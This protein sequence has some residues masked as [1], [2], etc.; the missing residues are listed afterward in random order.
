MTHKSLIRLTPLAFAFLLASPLAAQ[1]QPS[2]LIV[3]PKTVQL[4]GPQSIY[5]LLVT[6]KT[7]SGQL[8][9]LTHDAKYQ[10][11]HPAVAKVSATGV[12][13]GVADGK[14]EIVVE[15][16]GKTAKV[17]VEVQDTRE[18]R[19]YHFENDIM[20]ILSRSAAT[21]RAVTARPK[22]RTASSCRSSASIR[23]RDYTALVKEA[24]G[25]RVL[26]AAPEASLLLHEGVGPAAARRRHPHSPRDRR[27]RTHARL[28]RGRH[29][30]RRSDG[31]AASSPSAS[32]RRNAC[33]A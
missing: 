24:R 26:P 8:L 29:A 22:G 3:E 16:A 5:S 28:D 31:P 21:R 14:A 10:S 11:S 12:I 6:G 13:R 25:R 19:I 23:R 1:E 9:D 15:A 17:G 30:V 4:R 20:P 2:E 7:P 27:V 32:S 33:C 18:E